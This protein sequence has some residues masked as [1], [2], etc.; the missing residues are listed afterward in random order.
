MGDVR[1]TSMRTWHHREDSGFI[2]MAGSSIGRYL[3]SIALPV[4]L[5]STTTIDAKKSDMTR[6]L[7]KNKQIGI[8]PGGAREMHECNPWQ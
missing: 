4:C 8:F 1:L 5:Y 2:L 7:Q 6:A 3:P